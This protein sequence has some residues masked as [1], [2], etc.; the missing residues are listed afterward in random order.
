VD[1]SQFFNIF[2]GGPL[3]V[4]VAVVILVLIISFAASRYKVANA[5]E[6]LIISGARGNRVR[7][8]RGQLAAADTKGDQTSGTR[9]DKGIKV[10]V[11]GG[12][13][14]LPLVHRDGRISL[15]ARQ[16]QVRLDD[17]V[18]TQGIVVEVMGVATFKVGRTVE[19]IRN[20]AERFLNV[21]PTKID[22]IVKNVLEG[23]LRS[24][25]G[26][27]TIE[28][29]IRERSKLMEQV[30]SAAK[31]DLETS[32]LEI[33]AFTIQ[34][35]TDK[36]EYI[37]RLGE[38]EYA[39][40]ERDAAIA[41]AKADQESAVAQ[42]DAERITIEARQQVALRKAEADTATEA[43]AARAAQSAPLAQAE[44]QRQVVERQTELANLEAARKEKELL[45]SVVR[46]AEA[47]AEAVARRAD[48]ERQAQIAAAQ[49]AAEQVRLAGQAEADAI[50]ARGE[51]E[52]NALELRAEA[53]QKFNDAAVLQTVL[54]ELPRIVAAAAEPMRGIGSMTVLS[55]D[56]ASEVVRTATRTAAEG[57][58]VIKGMTGIDI[59]DLV[60]AAMG[61]SASRTRRNTK[62]GGNGGNNGGA[63][64]SEEEAD[65]QVDPAPFS[66][67]D[68]TSA[69][70]RIRSEAQKAVKTGQKAVAK[71]SADAAALDDKAAERLTDDVL[72]FD[73]QASAD[74]ALMAGLARLPRTARA[75]LRGGLSRSSRL[76]ALKLESLRNRMTNDSTSQG[77]LDSLLESYPQLAE[78]TGA[79]LLI[80][81]DSIE[82]T[83]R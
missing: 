6:A 71:A 17:A 42:A 2:G 44:A 47:E 9:Q 27:L 8:E 70:K 66:S 37:K 4:I 19:A 50:R 63:E 20:A 59:P 33:D 73:P 10:V 41:K 82:G 23:S 53:Y 46:P 5:N 78:K 55:S 75:L 7:D 38:Q 60:G 65:G 11:G 25:V 30:Q 49:G 79:D 22:E 72:G 77:A 3:A 13:I 34:S 61:S 64:S 67:S 45:A 40:V 58:A 51:A 26:T 18:T 57:N 15:L 69:A 39:V 28:E 14:V 43:A 21:D 81:L 56:G 54:A 16:I 35:I 32:G 1:F 62:P 74:A 76:R 29:L 31:G 24:I 83:V 80:L 12:A 52:A 36:S 48:G 68:A